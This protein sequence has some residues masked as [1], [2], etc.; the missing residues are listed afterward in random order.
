MPARASSSLSRKFFS[1]QQLFGVP[2][3]G[4]YVNETQK[5][6]SLEVWNQLRKLEFSL[7]AAVTVMAYLDNIMKLKMINERTKGWKVQSIVF[8]SVSR[9]ANFQ[10]G[11]GESSSIHFRNFNFKWLLVWCWWSC[12][13]HNSFK[14]MIWFLTLL[15]FFLN[16]SS[17]A[18]F[19]SFH[20]STG[21][22]DLCE[23]ARVILWTRKD[24]VLVRSEKQKTY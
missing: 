15:S 5:L 6:I 4:N 9:W 8:C 2:N 22:S 17:G 14:L 3:Q 1:T 16:Q 10:N 12:N 20:A 7:S 23:L 11:L 24:G 21:G 13:F 19:R 18:F